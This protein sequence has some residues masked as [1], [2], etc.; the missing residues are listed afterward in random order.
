M[1]TP[2]QAARSRAVLAAHTQ[3]FL[4]ELEKIRRS[5]T[6]DP[7]ELERQAERHRIHADRL[8]KV[9]ESVGAHTRSLGR[10][11]TGQ[12]YE[13]HAAGVRRWTARLGHVVRA[14]RAEKNWLYRCSYALRTAHAR[15]EQVIAAFRLGAQRV[16][17]KAALIPLPLLLHAL[18]DEVAYQSFIQARNVRDWLARILDEAE[19][20]KF[21][22]T[23]SSGTRN[24]PLPPAQGWGLGTGTE[25]TDS[26]EFLTW[27]M[28]TDAASPEA[29]AIRGSGGVALNLRAFVD[30]YED[31]RKWDLKPDFLRMWDMLGRNEL[32]T[33]LP[34]ELGTIHGRQAAMPFDLL[35]NVH[36]GYVSASLG[37]GSGSVAAW[38]ADVW[39]VW[40]YGKVDRGDQI[41]IEIGRELYARHGAAVRQ[42]HVVEELRRRWDDLVEVGKIHVR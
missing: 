39:D 34:P 29:A 19:V 30:L 28:R 25:F 22:T 3:H 1:I 10:D 32:S 5:V 42:E 40:K 36:F 20:R 16:A 27:R 21:P 8:Q 23:V 31:G 12:A 41:G 7:S 38:G 9:V 26:V 17:A 37:L 14:L 15:M 24:P 2:E 33:P 35:G 4:D 13:E 6:G 11:W 18:S